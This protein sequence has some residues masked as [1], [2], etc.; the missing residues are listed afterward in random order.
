MWGGPLMGF[1][2]TGVRAR[3]RRAEWDPGC[4][5]SIVRAAVATAAAA[6]MK[7]AKRALPCPVLLY[8]VLP[9]T[10]LSCPALHGP[11]LPCPVLPCP[12][13]CCL[14]LPSAL[15]PYLSCSAAPQTPYVLLNKQ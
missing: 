13:P 5:P 9:C 8:P 12:L 7:Q 3:L 14:T 11:V 6:A 2:A 4:S 10:D 15:L 1:P